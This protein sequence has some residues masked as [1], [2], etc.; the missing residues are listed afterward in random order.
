MLVPREHGAYGQLLFPLLSALV[1]G[2][3]SP[4]AF[5]LSAS[6]I[7]AFLAHE[8]L[9]VVLSQRGIRAAREQRSD[10]RRSLALFGGFCAVTGVVALVVLPFAA[11]TYLLVPLVLVAF[12][13]MAVVA[14]RERSTGGEILVATA[15]SAVSLP[16]AIA[17]GVP[18]IAAVTL[19]VV[20]ACVFITAT[21][22]VRSMIGRVSRAGGP[23]PGVAAAVTLAIV[24]ALALASAT[25]RL[26]SVAAFAALPVCAVA[27]GLTVRPPSPRHLRAVGWTLVGA[28]ALTAVLLVA[29]LIREM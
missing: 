1:I 21:V 18:R 4:G 2:Q 7:A 27:L 26:M 15:L 3:P 23:P 19:F 16:V 13:A 6:V 25:G 8:A 29:G 10:A 14:H 24:A 5:L 22:A 11:L 12:V 17:G 20:F 28:T 9:L